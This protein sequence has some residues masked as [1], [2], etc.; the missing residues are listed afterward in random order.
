MMKAYCQEFQ[1]VL[2][3]VERRVGQSRNGCAD[4]VRARVRISGMS[5]CLITNQSAV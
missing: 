2:K 4:D 1:D 3:S 5:L